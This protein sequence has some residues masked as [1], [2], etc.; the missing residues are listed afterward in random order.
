MMQSELLTKP[1]VAAIGEEITHD[2]AKSKIKAYAETYPTDPRCFLI[3][4]EII[5]KIIN[6]PGCAGIKFYNALY[7]DGTKTLV[8]VGVD[9]TGKAIIQISAI[10]N[11]GELVN[12]K[13]ITAN[14]P[15]G[16]MDE[17]YCDGWWF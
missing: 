4:K 12:N 14:R 13:G 1:N 17:T 15:F 6:Q 16:D 7:Q 3:G 2:L 10:N 11:E 5:Q 9:E 8:Y